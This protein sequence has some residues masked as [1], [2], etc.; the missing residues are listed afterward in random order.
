MQITPKSRMLIF[1]L[2]ILD[3]IRTK[4]VS[5]WGMSATLHELTKMATNFSSIIIDS[6]MVFYGNSWYALGLI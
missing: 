5:R 6:F 2:G 3:D 4:R 1:S